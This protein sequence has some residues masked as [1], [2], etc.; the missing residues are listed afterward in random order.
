MV[1]DAW[2]Y[3]LWSNQFI[4]M[5]SDGTEGHPRVKYLFDSSSTLRLKS[6]VDGKKVKVYVND[7]FVHEFEMQGDQACSDTDNLVGMWCHKLAHMKGADFKVTAGK[8]F[9]FYCNCN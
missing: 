1:N 6:V 5:S 2:G 8:I 9:F 7:M 3:F 4:Y